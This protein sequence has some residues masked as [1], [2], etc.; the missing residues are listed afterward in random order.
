ML[1]RSQTL[2]TYHGIPSNKDVEKRQLAQD[3]ISKNRTVDNLFEIF[4]LMPNGNMYML[5]PYSIQKTLK[6]NNY[7]FRG[8]FQESIKTNETYLGNAIITTASSGIREAIIATPVYSLEDNF[9]AFSNT[10]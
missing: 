4:Y 10:E 7:A 2:D 5:E 9:T 3:I 1:F 6:E 8:Y